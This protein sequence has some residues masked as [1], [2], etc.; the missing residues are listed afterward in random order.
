M[1]GMKNDR[2]IMLSM[3]CALSLSLGLKLISM[4]CLSFAFTF[5]DHSSKR[6]TTGNLLSGD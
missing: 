5:Y 3:F 1:E 6:K 2:A 4:L